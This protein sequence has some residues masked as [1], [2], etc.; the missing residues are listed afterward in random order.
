MNQEKSFFLRQ[1]ETAGIPF[2]KRS[3]DRNGCGWIACYHLQLLLSAQGLC[4]PPP[5]PEELAASLSRFLLFGGRLGLSPFVVAG[6]LY[7]LGLRLGFA[8]GRQAVMYKTKSCPGGVLYYLRSDIRRGAHFT[9]F[10][11]G[12]KKDTL[13]FYN[14]PLAEGTL[15]AFYEADSRANR[16]KRGPVLSFAILV[17]GKRKSWRS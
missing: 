3:S 13:R 17:K 2:G 7:S 8:P 4:A 15:E 1:S 16:C 12:E 11:A 9:A 14:G 5:P 10:C 6:Y